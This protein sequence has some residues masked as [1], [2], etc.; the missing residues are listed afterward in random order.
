MLPAPMVRDGA[1]RLELFLLGPGRPSGADPA[2]VTWWATGC[3]VRPQGEQV[4]PSSFR[5]TPGR[6]PFAAPLEALPC[7]R[8]PISTPTPAA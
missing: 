4:I 7:E 1:N 6:P 2:P 3:H 8:S 5:I